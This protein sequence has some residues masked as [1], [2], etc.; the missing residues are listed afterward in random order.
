MAGYAL[1]AIEGVLARN[2]T[3]LGAPI[4]EGMRLYGAL[5]KV[6]KIVLVTQLVDTVLIEHWLMRNEVRDHVSVMGPPPGSATLAE[7]RGHQLTELRS[8]GYPIDLV[9]DSSPAVIAE[10]MRLGVTGLLFASP[11]FARPE[12]RPGARREIREW[13]TIEAEMESQRLLRGQV[14]TPTTADLH[15]A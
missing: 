11:A 5:R 6:H 3:A 4:V 8:M 2:D 1:I 9:V 13:V 15:E 7:Q 10:V 14:V 12:F